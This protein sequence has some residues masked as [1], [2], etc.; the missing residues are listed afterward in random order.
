MV[1]NKNDKSDIWIGYELGSETLMKLTYKIRGSFDSG[2]RMYNI[3]HEQMYVDMCRSPKLL[4]DM[5]RKIL[6]SLH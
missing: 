3:D 5:M 1:Y 4:K 6:S 2:A